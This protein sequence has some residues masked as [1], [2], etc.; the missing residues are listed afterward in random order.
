MLEYE[1]LDCGGFMRSTFSQAD[2][3]GPNGISVPQGT[4]IK[5]FVPESKTLQVI[6]SIIIIIILIIIS[7]IIQM[8]QFSLSKYKCGH[9]HHGHFLS[10]ALLLLKKPITQHSGG[11][12]AEVRPLWLPGARHHCQPCP[13]SRWGSFRC[14]SILFGAADDRPC[15]RWRWESVAWGGEKQ[16]QR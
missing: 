5:N 10:F 12:Q 3:L 13:W 11:R 1:Q 14:G 16:C 9:L 4:P 8:I 15:Y 6:I 7:I 2:P